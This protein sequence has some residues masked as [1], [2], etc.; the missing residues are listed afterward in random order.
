MTFKTHK[1]D[2]LDFDKARLKKGYEMPIETLAMKNLLVLASEDSE[3]PNKKW[4]VVMT[5]DVPDYIK[6]EDVMGRL[7][8]GD[9]CQY[10]LGDTL[11]WIRV[12]EFN[13]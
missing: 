3:A 5:D 1:A 8:G 11:Y 12:E 9:M 4:K 13:E 6:S 7:V 2:V 10:P